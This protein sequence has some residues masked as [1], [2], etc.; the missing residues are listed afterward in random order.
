MLPWWTLVTTQIG[1]ENINWIKT[2]DFNTIIKAVSA[3]WSYE[4]QGASNIKQTSQ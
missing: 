3:G 2:L 4:K 1:L